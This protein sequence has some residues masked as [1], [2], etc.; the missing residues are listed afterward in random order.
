MRNSDYYGIEYLQIRAMKDSKKYERVPFSNAKIQK[1][2]D[3][4]KYTSEIMEHQVKDKMFK[5]VINDNLRELM[6]QLETMKLLKDSDDPR[7]HDSSN[8]VVKETVINTSINLPTPHDKDEGS[9]RENNEAQKVSNK[10]KAEIN[11]KHT[12]ML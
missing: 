4:L 10:H 11:F 12:V 3:D 9:N 8:N 5:L 6:D 7:N 2:I 1:E